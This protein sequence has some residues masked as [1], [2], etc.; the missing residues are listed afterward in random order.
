[1]FNAIIC[2]MQVHCPSKIA[3]KEINK[4][5][6]MYKTTAVVVIMENASRNLVNCTIN[7]VITKKCFKNF[8]NQIQVSHIILAGK[9]TLCFL[10]S[11]PTGH[12]CLLLSC[13]HHLVNDCCDSM[14]K[15]F[16]N[17]VK[18]SD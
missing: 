7:V 9:Q 16:T 17:L 4:H 3:I 5:K 14:E 18:Y 13:L 1:M 6:I 12:G 2:A 10:S 11:L 15:Y 8:G